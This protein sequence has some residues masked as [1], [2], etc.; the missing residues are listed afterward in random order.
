MPLFHDQS[1]FNEAETLYQ[2]RNCGVGV[3]VRILAQKLVKQM[4]EC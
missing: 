1:C 4:V 3:A 2:R